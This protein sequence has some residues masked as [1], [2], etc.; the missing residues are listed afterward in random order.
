MYFA[1]AVVVVA[2]LAVISVMI[3]HAYFHV[4]RIEV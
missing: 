1:A 3:F 4:P 2:F